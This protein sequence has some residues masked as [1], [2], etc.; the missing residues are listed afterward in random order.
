MAK[1]FTQ[2][3]YMVWGGHWKSKPRTLVV[4]LRD[5][6]CEEK[7]ARGVNQREGQKDANLA[8]EGRGLTAQAGVPTEHD[9]ERE[10]GRDSISK[11]SA[12]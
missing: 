3:I 2:L 4:R 5:W 12:Y 6:S 11:K 10:A 8:D 9:R 1:T 7:K